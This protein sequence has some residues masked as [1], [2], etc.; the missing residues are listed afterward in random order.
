MIKV[1]LF[2]FGG[3]LAEEGYREGLKAIAR[4]NGLDPEEFYRTANELI[5]ETGYIVG[6]ATEEEYWR[7]VKEK[8]GIKGTMEELRKE[9]LD[10]FVLRP[11]MFQI[12]R[13]LKDKGYRVAILSDQTNW[14]D[15]INEREDF[16]SLF[17]R[18]FN[19]YHIGRSKRQEETFRWVTEQLGVSPGEILFIDDNPSH[20]ERAERA[21]LRTFLFTTPEDFKRS[22]LKLLDSI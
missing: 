15:E 16:F 10:R 8:T 1:I 3:V 9:I 14:L 6:R 20:I 11:E 4:K 2:D 18:V 12:V 19:S 17:E 5:H 13:T 7:R 22:L 21:G